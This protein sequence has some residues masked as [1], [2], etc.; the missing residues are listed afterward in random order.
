MNLWLIAATALISKDNYY[1]PDP[2]FRQN[3]YFEQQARLE[4]E[5]NG[6][7]VRTKQ[8]G[9]SPVLSFIGDLAE[10]GSLGA[11]VAFIVLTAGAVWGG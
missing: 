6:N 7:I 2:T 4:R 8:V 3:I 11:F 10:L 1:F 9:G 5:H